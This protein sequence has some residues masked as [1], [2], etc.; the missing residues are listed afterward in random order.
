MASIAVAVTTWVLAAPWFAATYPPINDLPM[1]ASL[2]SIMRHYGDPAWHFREQFRPQFLQV[3][4]LTTYLVGALFALVVPIATAVKA[5]SFV[6]Q[7]MLP[8][9]LAVYAH[10]LKKSPYLGIAAGGFVWATLTQWGFLSYV[11]AIGLMLLG[12]GL[13]HLVLDAPSRRRMGALGVTALLLLL[14]HVSRF[15]FFCAAVALTTLCMWKVTRRWREVAIPIVPSVLVFALWWFVRPAALEGA[16]TMGWEVTKRLRHF[17]SDVFEFGRGNPTYGKHFLETL[18]AVAAY[19]L[20]VDVWKARRDE[21]R[22]L[23]RAEAF[24]LASALL[25]SL[26]FVGLYFSMPETIGAWWFV[27]DREMT[28]ALLCALVLMPRLPEGWKLRTPAVAG[29]LLAIVPPM[30]AVRAWYRTFEDGTADFRRVIAQ[31]PPAPRLGYMVWDNGDFARYVRPLL[32]LPAW[33]QAEKGGWLSFHFATWDATPFAFRHD[34]GADVA[35]PTPK[36]FEWTPDKFD[37]KERG[38]FFDWFLVHSHDS[39]DAVFAV[40]PTIHLVVHDGNWWI[41]H[42]EAAPPPPE[43]PPVTAP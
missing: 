2:T 21:R 35:P 8:V 27:Y 1:L 29:L 6:Q 11:G 42:R 18:L 5:A 38:R 14:T 41:Y 34:A 10:G 28:A 17:D 12:L 25:V 22:W 13:T 33:V 23:E 39:R 7:A 26:L 20:A 16:I 3:P 36:R 40:D 19:C 30:L 31:I 37:V 43:P 4:T 32:H 15:P 9:G 24:R